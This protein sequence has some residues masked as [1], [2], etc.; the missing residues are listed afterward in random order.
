[1]FNYSWLEGVH[2][3]IGDRNKFQNDELV[4][5]GRSDGSRSL[6]R[7]KPVR[8]LGNHKLRT[9]HDAT[10]ES[11]QGVLGSLLLM[12][13]LCKNPAHNTSHREIFSVKLLAVNCYC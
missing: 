13:N 10:F 12:Y 8:G 1:M 3:T 7:V 9:S 6:G 11:F 2:F 5:V 4:V